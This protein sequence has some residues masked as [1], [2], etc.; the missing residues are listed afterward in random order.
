MVVSSA[1]SHEMRAGV[2]GI[3][4]DEYVKSSAAGCSL[5][6]SVVEDSVSGGTVNVGDSASVAVGL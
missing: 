1:W 3:I 4:G 2:K 5:S 6:A